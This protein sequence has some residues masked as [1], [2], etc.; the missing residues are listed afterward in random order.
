MR[1]RRI[2]TPPRPSPPRD[3]R[4]LTGV[5]A[6]ARATAL[7]AVATFIPR[8]GLFLLLPLYARILLPEE[9]GAFSL[10]VSLAGLLAILFRL[11]LDATL[12][13][14]HF[15]LKHDL[16]RLY[17]TTLAMA[18][19]A[20]VLGVAVAAAV[21]API[22]GTLSAGLPYAPFAL[23]ALAIGAGTA[24]QFVPFAWFRA[25][26]RPGTFL[27][28]TVGSFAVT[29]VVSV[30]LVVGLRS[31]AAGALVGQLAT[32]VIT[33]LVAGAIVARLPRLRVD[34]ALARE[35]LRFSLPLVP[36]AAAAWVLNVSDRWL[37][38]LLLPGGGAAARA[39]I[40]VYWVGYQ[41]GYAIALLATS[42]QAAWLPIVYRQTDPV[43]GGRLI[44]TMMLF[45]AAGLFS[46]AIGVT[47][48]GPEVIE[49]VVGPG[50]R[51]AVPVLG[52][53]AIG[54][55][56][57]GIYA[58]V[59][60]VLLHAHRT[61]TL[62]ATTLGAGALNV[63]INLVAIPALGIAGA[64]WATVVANVA[65]VGVTVVLAGRT[66]PLALPRGRFAAIVGGGVLGALLL[67]I[68]GPT[69][70]LPMRLGIAIAFVAFAI[71]M[72]W[73]VRSALR[74]LG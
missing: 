20:V 48:L 14:F 16:G 70:D 49:L 37:L 62:A 40:G 45:A 31:G 53:V 57:Y 2:Q 19:V 25:V 1:R 6:F 21:L 15:D 7:Y 35:E 12:L 46:L 65:Y 51:D 63:A 24:L 56:A 18:L 68:G 54:S 22:F 10:V 47:A 33:A 11:G 5:R 26:E 38:A 36:H 66:W 52:L 4:P 69:L 73:P 39:E 60:P 41:I 32:A 42:L 27:V 55:V 71:G 28:Y 50:Y 9:L 3:H 34:R 17:A 74:E 58:V 61:G 44:G 67:L 29:A 13:R 72:T 23:L 8:V 64:A 30:A 43:A 59:V